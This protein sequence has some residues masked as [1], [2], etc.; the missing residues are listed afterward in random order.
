MGRF[1]LLGLFHWLRCTRQ[2]QSS[3]AKCTWKIYTSEPM[4]CY[5]LISHPPPFIVNNQNWPPV[6]LVTSV[7]EGGIWDRV[8]TGT[9]SRGRSSW[10]ED[11]ILGFLWKIKYP[12]SQLWLHNLNRLG[13][14]HSGF[15]HFQVL[16]PRIAPQRRPNSWQPGELYP[17]SVSVSLVKP[18]TMS[19][20]YSV[21]R[22]LNGSHRELGNISDG[23]F[24]SIQG[25]ST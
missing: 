15:E 16:I 14:R 2:T 8:Q 22:V 1:V 10:G 6:R 9:G 3:A 4:S 23:E 19:S 7:N 12:P 5:L 20:S 13:S 18:T 25:K 11:I 17:F 21:A 24:S